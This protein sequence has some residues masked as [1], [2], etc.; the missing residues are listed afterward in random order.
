MRWSREGLEYVQKR[1]ASRGKQKIYFIFISDKSMLLSVINRKIRPFAKVDRVGEGM[2]MIAS[3][4]K[5]MTR[6][7]KIC[8]S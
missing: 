3:C 4:W 2:Q 1:Q 8:A 7:V 6:N 5:G